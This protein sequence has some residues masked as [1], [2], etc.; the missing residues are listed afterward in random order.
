MQGLQLTKCVV[1]DVEIWSYFAKIR[2]QYFQ[3]GFRIQEKLYSFS[4]LDDFSIIEL[5]CDRIQLCYSKFE[6]YNFCRDY[7]EFIVVY[8]HLV[9][10]IFDLFRCDNY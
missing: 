5:F 2:L 4:H 7:L 8:Q 6:R 1:Q 10:Y 9:D 3:W